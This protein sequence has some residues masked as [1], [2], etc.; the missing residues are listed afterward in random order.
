MDHSNH[1]HALIAAHACGD[2]VESD[3]TRAQALMDTC[4]DCAE[5]HAD[6]LSIVSATRALPAMSAA[7]RDFRLDRTQA[8]RLGR[9]SWLRAALRPFASA[10]SA[11]R[12][13]AAAFTS[14]G[15]VGL[16]VASSLP[17]LVG[18]TASAPAPNRDASAAP[19]EA[20]GAAAPESPRGGDGR[21]LAEN[22]ASPVRDQA[23]GANDGGT[24]STTQAVAIAGG[25]TTS[26][27][28]TAETL[29]SPEPAGP[30]NP[31]LIGSLVLLL[32][33]LGLFA[34]RLAGRRLR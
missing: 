9:G 15:I 8:D 2:L 7:P 32:A 21:N 34:L 20:A 17:T 11:T 1:D 14:L 31:I 13:I 10:H 23:F 5:L 24:R 6:L 18:G 4:H 28:T 26:S 16:L 30:P 25:E 33:G 27:E 19:A 12:P 22:P 29:A 3:R